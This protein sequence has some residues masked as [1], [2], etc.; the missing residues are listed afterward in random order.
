MK[1]TKKLAQFVSGYNNSDHMLVIETSAPAGWGRK[2]VLNYCLANPSDD[3][4]YGR[5]LG[6]VAQVKEAIEAR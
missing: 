3:T 5:V 1:I 4:S 6:T 2:N